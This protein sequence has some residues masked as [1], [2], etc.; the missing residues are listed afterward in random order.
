MIPG[1][2]AP[3]ATGAQH[4]RVFL[5]C[6]PGRVPAA[7]GE[8]RTL[9]F[10]LRA[11][12]LHLL[13]SALVL[14]AVT[15][16]L[17]F[18]WYRWPGWFLTGVGSIVLM[19]AGV[20][21]ALGPTLTLLI[22]NPAKPARELARDVGIIV[23]VQLAA[24]GYAAFTMWSGRP[25][26]YAFS[27]DRFETVQASDIPAAEAETARRTNAALAPH[28]YSLPRW[29]Y[30]PLPDDPKVADE[31]VRA[32]ISGG[33]DVIDMPR[34]FRP[35]AT[36]VGALRGELHALDELKA[37]SKSD[38]RRLAARLAAAGIAADA[39]NLIALTGRGEPL[40]AVVD[41]ASGRVLS[42]P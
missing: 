16:V 9:K 10:R 11:F 37:L 2:P 32:A 36:G 24:L 35:W 31:I 17:Y 14:G 15:A 30:A 7:T 38:R 42:I 23:V 19:M 21:L 29:V 8:E 26:Y 25:L 6:G 1:A 12:A 5:E 41:A 40:V 3:D 4:G 27:A 22:A 18:G 39:R 13:G 20:D 34:Y 33:P 28:W